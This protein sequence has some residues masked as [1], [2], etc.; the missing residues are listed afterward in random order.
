MARARAGSFIFVALFLRVSAQFEPYD[1]ST[2]EDT[3]SLLQMYANHINS[4]LELDKSD[5]RIMKSWATD[6]QVQQINVTT[7]YR[8]QMMRHKEHSYY[9]ING[10]AKWHE[11]IKIH[12]KDIQHSEQNYY[13]AESHCL[14]STNAN[15]GKKRHA[16]YQVEKEIK[17]WR[18]SY[19]YLLNKCKSNNPGDDVGTGECLVDYVKRDNY[20]VTFQRLIL[21]KLEAMSDLFKEMRDSLFKLEECL[22]GTLSHYLDRVRGITGNL[23]QCY[24]I[25]NKDSWISYFLFSI[26]IVVTEVREKRH[27]LLI[28]LVFECLLNTGM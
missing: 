12:R 8:L 25:K 27:F 16:V 13:I 20:H 2:P 19:R 14:K 9:W 23:N 5:R 7:H 4:S 11:C 6:F 21:L 15:E 26:N 17:K 10:S 18:K 22:K 1:T 24:S 3:A 28:T